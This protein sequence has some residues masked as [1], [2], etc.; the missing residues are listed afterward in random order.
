VYKHYKRRY[1]GDLGHT[2]EGHTLELVCLA[3]NPHGT[4]AVTGSMDSTA[5]VWSVATG[6]P[7]AILSDHEGEIISTEFNS[8]GDLILTGS[9]DRTAR[10]W[11]V[12]TGKCVHRLEA[13]NG[14][15]R[16]CMCNSGTSTCIDRS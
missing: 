5:R 8:T 12:R 6:A 3:F 9:F 11:D 13:H 10:V 15:V 4:M 2:L 1:A 7:L 16:S 14:E